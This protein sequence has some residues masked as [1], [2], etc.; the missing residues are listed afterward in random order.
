MNV[1]EM[2]YSCKQMLLSLKIDSSVIYYISI[3]VSP[4]STSTSSNSLPSSPDPFPQLPLQK[5]AGL[6]ERTAKQDETRYSKTKQKPSNWGWTGQLN[7]RKSLKSRPRS[8][9]QTDS[10]SWEATETPS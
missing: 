5:G 3:T 1:S 6:Q 10:H 9:R 2:L 8:L 7:R 4:P